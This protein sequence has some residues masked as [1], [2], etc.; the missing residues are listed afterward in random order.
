[1]WCWRRMEEIN[2]T[3][4]VRNKEVHRVKVDRNILHTIRKEKG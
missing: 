3:S 2:W 1:M 4:R